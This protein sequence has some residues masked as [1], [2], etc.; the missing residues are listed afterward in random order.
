M[1]EID[2][3]IL[4]DLICNCRMTYQELSR[5]YGISANAIR[6][7]VLNLEE[8]G[9]IIGYSLRLAPAMTDTHYVFGLMT[10]D[11]SRNEID[12]VAEIGT[13]PYIIAASSYSCG[14]Y[15]C[16][17][18]YHTPEQLLELG[19]HLRS[20]ESLR[21][22]EMHTLVGTWGEKMELTSLH[23]RILRPLMKNPRMSIVDLA[24]ETGLTARRVRRL[25]NEL[26]ERS[27]IRFGAL[28]ELGA[29]SSLPFIVRLQWNEKEATYIDIHEWIVKE[30]VLN[31]WETYISSS[32]PTIFSLMSAENLTEV[33]QLVNR[34]RENKSIKTLESIIGGHHEYFKGIRHARLDELLGSTD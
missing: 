15:A 25:L 23:K 22:V 19:R 16:I 13:S 17:G 6:R 11:G 31:H 24:A 4:F 20:V 7:R 8:D 14:H 28:Y 30:F 12:I 1:D 34:L 10:C 5:K 32:E 21:D 9:V 2:K 29:A 18:E 33:Q 26:E 27:A 3:G